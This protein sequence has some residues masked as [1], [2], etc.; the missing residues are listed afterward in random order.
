MKKISFPLLLTLFLASGYCSHAQNG[1]Y[2]KEMV[3][4]QELTLGTNSTIKPG[5]LNNPGADMTYTV[6][7]N[8]NHVD[9]GRKQNNRGPFKVLFHFLPIAA[10]NKSAFT[11]RKR[12]ITGTHITKKSKISGIELTS[13]GFEITYKPKKGKTGLVDDYVIV[14]TTNGDLIL[15]LTGEIID[16]KKKEG[17]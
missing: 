14:H 12:Q 17:Q 13:N 11:F 4:G 6:D 7:T 3:Y 5:K 16:P 15:W 1:Q 9:F 10:D 8:V 2:D